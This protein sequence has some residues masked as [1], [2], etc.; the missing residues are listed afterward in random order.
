[1][2]ES[3]PPLLPLSQHRQENSPSLKRPLA[4]EGG[5]S[6]PP[7]KKRKLY[8]P[9]A[10]A[11]LGRA[12]SRWFK[13]AKD[14]CES[15]ACQTPVVSI[16]RLPVGCRTFPVPWGRKQRTTSAATQ[17]CASDYVLGE[18]LSDSLAKHEEKARCAFNR[19]C[20]NIC[21]KW[22]S[23]F[24]PLESEGVTVCEQTESARTVATNTRYVGWRSPAQRSR[25]RNSWLRAARGWSRAGRKTDASTQTEEES[26]LLQ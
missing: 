22:S 23:D 12:A 15:K 5:H 3:R 13:S 1:M 17:T 14:L 4:I 18:T 6:T 10:G 16:P 26:T 9:H 19:E 7:R 24:I 25:R 8:R 2:T 21:R 20:E 11:I